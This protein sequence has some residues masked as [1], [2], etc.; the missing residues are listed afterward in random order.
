MKKAINQKFEREL[1]FRFAVIITKGKK[2]YQLEYETRDEAH[3][4]FKRYVNE[5]ADFCQLMGRKSTIGLYEKYLD[6]EIICRR[7]ITMSGLD[8]R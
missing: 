2:N 6:E 1:H 8:I 4:M 3:K 5:E 7:Q